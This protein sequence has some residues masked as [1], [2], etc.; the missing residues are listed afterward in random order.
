MPLHLDDFLKAGG[1]LP[2]DMQE[3]LEKKTEPESRAKSKK[4]TGK[5]P[6]IKDYC[7]TWYSVIAIDFTLEQKLLSL[8]PSDI[9]R[10]P[11]KDISRHSNVLAIL[12]DYCPWA[13]SS[14]PCTELLDSKQ[15]RAKLFIQRPSSSERQAPG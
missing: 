7:D 4:P 11:G 13:K 14:C 12:G 5:K 8:L 2:D 10:V 15:C 6:T 9:I 3:L 1:K